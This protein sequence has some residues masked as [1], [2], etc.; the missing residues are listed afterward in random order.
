[1][2][3]TSSSTGAFTSLVLSTSSVFF[4]HAS[5]F[6]VDGLLF[7]QRGELRDSAWVLSGN[8][9]LTVFYFFIGLSTAKTVE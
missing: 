4:A 7:R 2:Y 5:V 8:H 1:M 3:T 9:C 6:S